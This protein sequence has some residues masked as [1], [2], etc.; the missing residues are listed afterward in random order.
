MSLSTA[1]QEAR[2]Q[3]LTADQWGLRA[4]VLTLLA[5]LSVFMALPLLAMLR[6]SLEDPNG[7]FVGLANYIAYFSTPALSGSLWNSLFVSTVTTVIVLPLAFVFAFAITR[8]R[9]PGQAMFRAIVLVPVLAPSLLPAIALVY[10]FGNHGMAKS[11]LMGHSIYGPIGIVIAQVFFNLPTAVMLLA[12]TLSMADQ[13]LYESAAALKTPRWRIWLTITWPEVR[14]GLVSCALVT[15]VKVITDFGGAI[16]I[17]GGYNVLATDIYKQ[18]V[19]QLNF[20]MGAVIGVVLMV[21]AIIAFS[22]NQA[23]QRRQQAV[24]TARSVPYSPPSSR[25]RDGWL[26][27]F[28]AL[29][30]AFIL[31]MLGVAVWGSFVTYWPYDL[32]VSLKNYRFENFDPSGWTPFYNAVR[33]A[34]MTSGIGTVAVFLGAYAMERAKGFGRVVSITSMFA[35]VPLAVPGLVLG[36]SYVIF[37]N[38][39]GNPLEPLLGTLL[40]MAIGTLVHYYT[41][42]HLTA[43][44]AIKQLDAEFEAVAASLKVSQLRTFVRV[45]LPICGPAVM[46]IAAFL[47][48]AAMASVSVLIFI[49]SPGT[50]VASVAVVNINDAGFTAAAAAMASCIVA[51]CAV[52]KLFHSLVARG[53]ARRTSQWRLGSGV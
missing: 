51:V 52:F 21:P 18:V 24:L 5:L 38:A 42:C 49:Y 36:L 50:R 44:T 14:F 32:T 48:L 33:M 13:R 25:I 20:G 43:V 40:L 10:L 7:N 45:T 29:V 9:M 53:I 17:G 39:R 15:F 35:M 27:A 46:E 30:A 2:P 11:V 6:K 3:Y 31:L 34:A 12:A 23:I 16:V 28:C 8:S 1:A 22:G 19:G 4:L 37:F 47:F 26:L 41:V